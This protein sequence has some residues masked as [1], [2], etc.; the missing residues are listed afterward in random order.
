M[1]R[2][3]RKSNETITRRAFMKMTG[4]VVVGAGVGCLLPDW[5]WLNN[6]V[7][8]IAASEGY[9]LVERKGPEKGRIPDRL[10]AKVMEAGERR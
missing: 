3:H 7:A 10:E 8:A 4:K 9:L 2:K 1:S 5:I 6:S